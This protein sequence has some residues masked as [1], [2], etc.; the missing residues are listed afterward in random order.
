MQ[1]EQDIR[2]GDFRQSGQGMGSGNLALVSENHDGTA[3]H[4]GDVFFVAPPASIGQ[5]ITGTTNVNQ[6]FKS[7]VARPWTGGRIGIGLLGAIAGSIAGAIIAGS[8]SGLRS[9]E[10]VVIIAF[11][12]LGFFMLAL[13][14]KP[15]HT[16]SYVGTTGLGMFTR[17]GF[18]GAVQARVF[19]FREAVQLRT[20]QV[21]HYTNGAYTGDSFD[22]A[23]HGAS[24]QRVFTLKGRFY[25]PKKGNK[26][27]PRDNS[28]HIAWGGDRAWS[29]YRLPQVL[30]Q[31]DQGQVVP[32]NIGKK[33][34]IGFGNGFI[35]MTF[36]GT[37][38]RLQKGEIGGITLA[39]GFMTIQAV[40]AK[41]SLF[42][43]Q[44]I[45]TF[46]AAN[47]Q[48]FRLFLILIEKQLGIRV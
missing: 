19:D 21:T 37:T 18:T 11:G 45:F 1:I 8:V 27:I 30:D 41:K 43:K 28:V 16:C 10:L 46:S 34:W 3:T 47:V 15:K 36:K 32:F 13:P 9:L 12:V 25:R 38:Q 5:V 40:G 26:V 20:Q 23:W 39:R 35:D 31:L 24:G 22:Y 2:P 4:P 33:D 17:K 14:V 42:N 44:G 29:L 48:D 6:A 7:G